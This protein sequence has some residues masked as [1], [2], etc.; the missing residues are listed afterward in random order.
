MTCCAAYRRRGIIAVVEGAGSALIYLYRYAIGSERQRSVVN[1][2]LELHSASRFRQV[3]IRDINYL[4]LIIKGLLLRSF[5]FA[6]LLL[7][8]RA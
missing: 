5:S 6:L 7:Q 1:S 8:E 4:L 3:Q 2:I